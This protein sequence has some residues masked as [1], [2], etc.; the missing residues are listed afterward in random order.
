MYKYCSDFQQ[1]D[2]RDI[3]RVRNK[4]TYECG[5][6]RLKTISEDYYQQAYNPIELKS[7]GS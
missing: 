4:L 3:S 5:C 1:V 6:W 2:R 7:E